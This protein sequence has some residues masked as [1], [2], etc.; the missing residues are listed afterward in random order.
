MRR[1][2]LCLV[3]GLMSAA[4]AAVPPSNQA[5]TTT[6]TTSAAHVYVQGRSGVYVFN[7]NSAGQLTEVGGSPFPD[8][9]EME[10]VRG[11][12]LL[13]SVGTNDLHSYALEANGAVGRQLA[14]IDTA[15][16]RG[17]ECGNTD[18]SGSILDHTGQYFSVQLYGALTDDGN[19][20]LCD[21]W[22]TYKVAANGEFTYVG[23]WVNTSGSG[24]YAYEN[25]PMV[26]DLRTVSSNDKYTYGKVADPDGIYFVPFTRASSGEITLNE[27]FQETDPAAK[28]GWQPYPL[29][30]SPYYY[31]LGM[32]ADNA[33][34]LAAL[35]VGNGTNY[36]AS[37][38]INSSNGSITS[39]NSWKNMPTT[40]HNYPLA[41]SPDGNL[42]A[43]GSQ[44]EKAGIAVF[45]FNGAAPPTYDTTLLPNVEIDELAWDKSNHL[46]ALS[47]ETDEL[48]V[49]TI[50]PTSVKAVSGSPWAV[51]E[52]AMGAWE[53]TGFAVVPQ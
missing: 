13:I 44:G 17:S 49:Y 50:T 43:L 37:Y 19:N 28:P 21:A 8:A 24:P 39:T 18:N 10:A 30:N 36:V 22:Q 15:K 26:L 33:G 31:P 34:H 4:V 23:A 38:T 6:A 11:N 12:D 35:L 47:Y 32:A 27:D 16:Y 5:Q 45:H 3:A 40:S 20:Y 25:S 7:A 29:P 9:G 1:S 51:P 2:S 52:A 41:M 48:Y 53:L 42:V 46:Y 14:E